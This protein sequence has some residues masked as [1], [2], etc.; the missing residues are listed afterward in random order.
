MSKLLVSIG[1]IN[2]C[3]AMAAPSL[4]LALDG[5]QP[6]KTALLVIDVQQF[7][8]A[9][10]GLPLHNPEAASVNVAK[11]ISAFR[12]KG[13]L[14]I[15][16]GHNAKSGA[17]FHPDVQPNKGEKVIFKDEVSAFNGTDLLSYLKKKRVKKLVIVGMQTH[18]CVEG[19][20]RAAHDLGFECTV[21]ADACATR[22]LKFREKVVSADDVH[23][24]TLAT[25]DGTYAKVM[26]TIEFLSAF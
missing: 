16:V 23:N 8:F 10:G 6:A 14:V 22:D 4:A 3:L 26:D 13:E 5:T 12:A 7:Y 15:H 25:L 9:G 11:L 24:S 17:E 1:L 20:T 2:G 21:I 18:M 19:T